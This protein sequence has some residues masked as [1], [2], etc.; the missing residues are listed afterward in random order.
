MK[1]AGLAARPVKAVKEEAVASR[2]AVAEAAASA[3]AAAGADSIRNRCNR[4]GT[5]C[6]S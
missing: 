6:V 3:V 2:V 4:H 1:A 5:S